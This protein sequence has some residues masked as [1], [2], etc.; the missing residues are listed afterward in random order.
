MDGEHEVYLPVIFWAVRYRITSFRSV[1]S[2]IFE[3]HTE[4]AFQDISSILTNF[5]SPL[6]A[7][8]PTIRS[9]HFQFSQVRH[10]S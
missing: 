5:S 6:A 8:L 9:H 7:L 2:S 3:T 1:M 10:F 4:M